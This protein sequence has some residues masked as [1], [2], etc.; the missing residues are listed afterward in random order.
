MRLSWLWMIGF[1]AAGCSGSSGDPDAGPTYWA[2]VR[3]IL[4]ESCVRC[5]TDGGLAPISFDDPAVVVALANTI[6]ARVDAGT[7]PPPAPDP[8]CADYVDSDRYTLDDA[9]KA[10]LHQWIEAGTPLGDEADRPAPPE[11]FSIA[12]FDVVVQGGA[13]YTPQFTSGDDDYRCWAID[14]GNEDEVFLTGMEA[15]VEHNA[16]VHHV[17]LFDD[18]ASL[19]GGNDGWSN[20][21]DPNDADG[22]PCGGFG[23]GDW[24]F[25]HGW[26]PGAAPIDFPDGYGLKLQAHAKLVVQAHYFNNGEIVPDIVG[27]GLNFAPQVETEVYNLPVYPYQFDHVPAG[28]PDYTASETFA[29]MDW[30][31]I[32]LTV[33]VLSVWPHMH[34][35]GTGFDYYITHADGSETCMVHE[36]GWDFHNQVPAQFLQ[37]IV[38][39]SDSALTVEC[40]YDN[41][42]SN[43]NQ[44]FDPPQN[45]PLGEGTTDEMCFAF[46]Y[47]FAGTP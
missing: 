1:V 18:G 42:A 2:D 38:V 22:F 33:S 7:M 9:E 29:L 10:V 5:H 3:P 13:P 6:A 16:F 31:P 34:V 19:L 26:G 35:L 27:Y 41:S 12:P 21:A 15:I 32:P 11:A 45:V 37:P 8:S 4:D 46:T 40:H 28:D 14:V 44:F 30:L 43:P 39:P 24:A 47:A 25:L 17:V 36:D 23:G 20:G